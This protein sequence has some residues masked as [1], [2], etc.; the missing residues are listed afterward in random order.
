MT[1][2]A[3]AY[4]VEGQTASG[5]ETREG[6]TVAADPAVLP[7][8]T[9]VQ[10]RGAGPYSGVYTVQD[11]GRKVAGR[12]IDFF[13]ADNAEAKKFG[14]QTVKVRIVKKAPR[15]PVSAQ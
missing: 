3:T 1:F 5:K 6:T 15:K 14:N 10:V 2:N 7:L 12:S 13:I 8:G 4:S 11:T 9:R